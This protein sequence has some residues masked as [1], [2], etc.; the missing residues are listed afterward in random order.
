[1]RALFE[2]FVVVLALAT[3]GILF[4]FLL[5]KFDAPLADSIG[6]GLTTFFFWVGIALVVI[7]ILIVVIVSAVAFVKIKQMNR[8]QIIYDPADGRPV[9]A[10]VHKGQ[11]VQ[12]ST[13]GMDADQT[14]QQIAQMK[15][16]WAMLGTASTSMRNM[17]RFMDELEVVDADEDEV[18]ELDEEDEELKQIGGPALDPVTASA[19]SFRDELENGLMERDQP[20]IFGY[21]VVTDPYTKVTE[22]V[23]ITDVHTRTL[24]LAGWSGTGK[25]TLVACSMARRAR[26]QGNVVF[27]V[28]DPHKGAEE[29]SLA[30]Q[31]AAP[32]SDWLIQ[33]K[34]GEKITGKKSSE[35]KA[36]V[37]FLKQEIELR[38]DRP[39]LTVEQKM[40]MSP[41][42]GLN[43]WV[44]VDEVLSYARE[45]R[46]SKHDPAFD[47]LMFLLQT[48]ATDTR[49]VGITGIYMTQLSTKEQLGEIEIKDACPRR[50]IL[51]APKDQGK[52][53]GL[54]GPEAA[55]CE[56]FPQGRGYYMTKGMDIFVWGY[57]SPRDIRD[58]LA[59]VQSPIG[60][61][62]ENKMIYLPS[63]MA[64][65]ADALH[66]L[67]PTT[68][69]DTNLPGESGSQVGPNRVETT[70]GNRIGS[71]PQ[72]LFAEID[73]ER[74]QIEQA[75]WKIE[76]ILAML[77]ATQEDQFKAI[78]QV[79]PGK[80]EKYKKARAERVAI[81]RYIQGTLISTQE[82]TIDQ[83]TGEV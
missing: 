6:S 33:P 41:Y 19:P 53:L 9:R 13:N 5:P 15:Q 21:R 29:D 17:S 67:S 34:G 64:G 51:Q 50:V 80:G 68:Q 2:K 79:V 28:F 55:L 52:A 3:A 42:Y 78:W 74:W 82:D 45:T 27:L 39:D 43:I 66:P 57:G 31:I 35:V 44:I 69:N 72:A 61:Q 12:L 36:A 62:S 59:G 37:G 18:Y 47:D 76:R 14:A 49:K 63:R 1:M 71:A 8:T 58:A 65:K 70:T 56:R 26:T 83:Q 30:V 81:Y 24:F 54:T 11:L 32:F 25:S 48:I 77:D 10:V 16:L 46:M 22:L 23:P 75:E 73:G 20:F 60:R 7:F 4:L 38:L 40:Q